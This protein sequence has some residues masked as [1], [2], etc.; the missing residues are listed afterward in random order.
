MI[1][2]AFMN[3]IG[4]YEARKIGRDEVAGLIVSTCNTSDEGY[5]TALCD[6][7]GAHPVE[8][9]ATA[10]LAAKGHRL[11]MASAKNKKLKTVKKLG[12]WGVVEDERITLVR[13]GE[14]ER[15]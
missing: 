3:D 14:G 4:N 10:E 11:W 7:N 1:N 8:R 15:K 9:Y 5:E 6:Q 12:A 13:I 2:L